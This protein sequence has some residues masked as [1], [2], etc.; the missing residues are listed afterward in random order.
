MDAPT[1]NEAAPV[2]D[3]APADLGGFI[4]S[5]DS[6]FSEVD[7]P[8]STAEPSVLDVPAVKETEAAAEPE[9]PVTDLDSLDSLDEP[10]DW[11]PQ[12]ARRF[13]ELKNELKNYKT[14]AEELEQTV[15]QRESRLQELEAVSNNPEFQQLQNKVQEY[16]QSMLLN[17]LEQS[18]AYKTLV[19]QPLGQLVLEADAIAQKY[20]VDMDNLLDVISLSDDTLQEEQLSEILAQASDRDKFRVYKIIEEVKPILEQ[21]RVLQENVQDALREAQAL[22]QQRE[23]ATLVERHQ[24]RQEAAN[25]VAKTIKSKLSFLSTVDGVDMDQI[26]KDAASTDFTKLDAVSGTYQAMAAKLLPKMAAQYI[27]LQKEIDNLT[28][29][30]ADFD[31]ASPK[32]GGGS[33]TPYSGNNADSKKSFVDAVAAA[34]GG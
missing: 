10:K 18:N 19:E 12:A 28:E 17:N 8:T 16:E 29:R 2:A 23:Q 27:S 5:M 34:F 31:R 9:L 4:E 15:T 6:F 11:T 21:R 32:A 14:R 26:A 33:A 1:P 30:L 3:T 7:N 13:K 25:A 24:Q 22:D 20:G